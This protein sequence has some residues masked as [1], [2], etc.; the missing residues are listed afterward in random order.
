MRTALT[1]ATFHGGEMTE[2]LAGP[3][4]P[5]DKQRA[6]IKRIH[7]RRTHPK[8]ERVEL[9]EKDRGVT[10]SVRFRPEASPSEVVPQ[11]EQQAT[12]PAAEPAPASP[13][14]STPAPA[15]E[16]PA[17]EP[18]PE[19]VPDN[20]GFETSKPQPKGKAKGK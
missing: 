10:V 17:A 7:P 14:E 3:D 16:S 6:D 13:V 15:P 11:Q 1:I 8:W 9:W 18:E 19:V 4:T 12:P 2:L 5:I 20:A